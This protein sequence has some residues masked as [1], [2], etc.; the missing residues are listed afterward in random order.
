MELYKIESGIFK[1]DG[2]AMFGVVP[3]VLWNKIYPADEN[4]QCTWS[5][6]CLLIVDEDRR[7]LIDSGVG[8]KQDEKFRRNFGLIG[9]SHLIEEINK[10]GFGAEDITDVIHTHLHF[11]HCGGTIKYDQGKNLVPTFPNATLWVGKRHWEEATNPNPRERASF[12]KENILPM[13]ESGKLKLIEQEGEILPNIEIRIFNGHTKG[14]VVPII[15]F[16][17]RKLVY[18]GDLFPSS[19][20]VYEPYIM[21]YDM[22]ARET[23]ADKERFFKEAIANDYTLFF[24]HDY[25]N[26][27]ATIYKTEKGHRIKETFTLEQFIAGK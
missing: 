26:E 17:G 27:C 2:G 10:A 16:N 22:C 8:D 18:S 5:M 24:E 3:K 14:Q 23:L 12:L 21:A 11:D 13:K 7:I 4:N 15:N 6:R 20:H 9:Q 25:Y 1:L 19:A